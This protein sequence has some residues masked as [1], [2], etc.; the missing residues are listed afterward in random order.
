MQIEGLPPVS[1]IACGGQHSLAAT[2]DGRV[3]AWG[4]NQNGCLGQGRK[5]Q[6][7][8]TPVP[9]PGLQAEQVAAG[10]KH[11]AAVGPGGTLY[12]WG[13]GGSQGEEKIEATALLPLSPLSSLRC[14][15]H[16]LAVLCGAGTALSLDAYGSGGG[17]LGL[18]NE[19]DYWEPAKV[20]RVNMGAGGDLPQLAANGHSLWRALQVSCGLNHT[21]AIVEISN[22]VEL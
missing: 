13:W 8:R 3:A 10:W 9:V 22:D 20:L 2:T 16:S 19:N 18:G 5:A 14:R 6:K 11:S 1:S 17:Q 12:T 7:L 21:A 15:Q 4:A